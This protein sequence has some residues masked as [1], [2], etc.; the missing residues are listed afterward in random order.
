LSAFQNVAD[1]LQSLKADAALLNAEGYAEKVS[2]QSLT[3]TQSQFNAGASN[4]LNVL[5]AEQTLLNARI[6]R[7]KAQAARLADTVALFQSLGGGWWNRSDESPQSRP[8][9]MTP[10]ALFPPLA[11]LSQSQAHPNR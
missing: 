7:V 10:E 11:A 5:N 9:P 8:A 1:S 6:G 3:I 4:T 2:A